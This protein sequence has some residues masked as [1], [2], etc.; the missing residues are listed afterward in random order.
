[1]LFALV[2]VVAPGS[3]MRDIHGLVGLGEMP[4]TAIVWYLARSLSAFYAMMGGL[5]WVVSFNVSHYY[6][7]LSYLGWT[8]TVFGG[9]LCVIDVQAAMPFAWTMT[10]GPFVALFGVVILYLISRFEHTPVPNSA[11]HPSA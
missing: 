10:E 6:S 1:M 5:F 8:T 4:D 3:W 7:V 11:V 9:A 2:F